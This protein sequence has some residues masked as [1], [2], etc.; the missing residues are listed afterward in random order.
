MKY[1]YQLTILTPTY[2]RGKYLPVLYMSLCNQ[3][4]QSFQWLIIDDGSTDDSENIIRN[5]SNHQ[6]FLEYLRKSNGG[7]HTAINYSHP[8]IRGEMV[9]IV[10]SDDW[11]LPEATEKILKVKKIFSGFRNIKLLTFLRGRNS[12][13]PICS[14]FPKR[15]TISNHINFRINSHRIGDCCEVI[16]T[17]VLKEFPFPEHPKEK[18]LGE[19]YLWNNTGFKYDTVYVPDI[20]YICKY[21]ENGLT[22][23]GRKLRLSCPLGGMDNC[24]SFFQDINGR[25]INKRTLKKEALLF[26]CYGKLAGFNYRDI[27]EQSNSKSLIKK[28]YILGCLLYFYWKIKYKLD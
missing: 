10:D 11:L 6:F 1:E 4:N 25:V 21:L 2:N 17:D 23:S 28:N 5:F 15:I 8:Y 19:G 18:F 24:N 12:K 3:I 20:I 9:C 16:Y 27:V 26:I 7:K 14:Q 22:K 13:D